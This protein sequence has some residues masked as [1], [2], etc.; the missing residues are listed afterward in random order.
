MLELR[1]GKVPALV[2]T[3][4]QFSC[5]RSDV[6]EY[7][8][9][10]GEPCTFTLCRVTCSLADGRRCEVTDAVNLHVKLLSFS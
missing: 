1:V 3:G 5:V 9:L 2:D 8:Y 10:R 4:A 6:A 7:L